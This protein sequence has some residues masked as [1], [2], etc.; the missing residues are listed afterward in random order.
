MS[1]CTAP[2]RVLLIKGSVFSRTSVIECLW[3]D[4]QSFLS[5]GLKKWAFTLNSTQNFNHLYRIF[6]A[7]IIIIEHQNYFIIFCKMISV[8]L[9]EPERGCCWARGTSGLWSLRTEPGTQ[10]GLPRARTPFCDDIDAISSMERRSCDSIGNF[11]E[12]CGI[13]RRC[14]KVEAKHV[15]VHFR[16]KK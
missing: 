12:N 10:Q 15:D 2:I 8:F 5:L 3:I 1:D 16:T 9:H 4:A 6:R 11:F 7:Y 14:R 13:S